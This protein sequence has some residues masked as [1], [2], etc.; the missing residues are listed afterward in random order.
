M[1][2]QAEDRIETVSASL[3]AQFHTCRS[4]LDAYLAVIKT[5]DGV[6]SPGCMDTFL[7]FVR[8]NAQLAGAIA[9]LGGV[10]NRN[11]KTQ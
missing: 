6:I 2:T 3:E 7:K 11:S 8:T 9:R 4:E 1:K 10:K 5:S